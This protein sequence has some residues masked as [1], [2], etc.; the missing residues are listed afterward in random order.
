MKVIPH[1]CRLGAFTF[2]HF[3]RIDERELSRDGSKEEMM[4]KLGENPLREI[5]CATKS[6][7]SQLATKLYGYRAYQSSILDDL[8][9]Y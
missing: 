9:T 6:S 2:R 1:G 4:W 5:D 7:I 3:D 8:E